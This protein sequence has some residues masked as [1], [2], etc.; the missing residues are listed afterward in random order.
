MWVSDSDEA[1]EEE[2]E[3]SVRDICEEKEEV[4]INGHSLLMKIFSFVKGGKEKE[5]ESTCCGYF[6]K[7]VMMLVSRET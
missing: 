1:I 6:A 3:E 2:S 5:L 4:L 7:I